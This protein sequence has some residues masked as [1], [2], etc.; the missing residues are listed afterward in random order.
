MTKTFQSIEYTNNFFLPEKKNPPH[1]PTLVKWN[2]Q[3]KIKWSVN[4]INWFYSGGWFSI[5]Q[6][7]N[8]LNRDTNAIQW[9]IGTKSTFYAIYCSIDRRLF[10]Y[11]EVFGTGQSIILMVLISCKYKWKALQ[12]PYW[13][14]YFIDNDCEWTF[15]FEWLYRYTTRTKANIVD[16]N[17][18]LLFLS[19][20]LDCLRA[21]ETLR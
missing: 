1:N 3:D 20:Y 2:R 4:W 19:L 5:D 9:K 16:I 21:N 18:H 13:L 11:I 17:V 12:K 6:Y 7:G 8:I 14:K 10:V 15:Q